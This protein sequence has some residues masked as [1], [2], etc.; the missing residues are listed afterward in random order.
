MAMVLAHFIIALNVEAF[1]RRTSWMEALSATLRGC[2]ATG[3]R[4]HAR[5]GI[6]IDNAARRM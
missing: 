3:T 2:D 1:E 4:T 6:R 5:S